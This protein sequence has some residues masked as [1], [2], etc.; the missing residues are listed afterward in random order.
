MSFAKEI[1]LLEDEEVGQTYV[2]SLKKYDSTWNVTWV[3]TISEVKAI[4]TLDQLHVFI[5]DQR[6]SKNE[7]GTEAFKYVHQ[8]NPRI[9]GVMLSGV[10]LAKDLSEAEKIIHEKIEYVNKE[11]VLDLPKVVKT[12]I[13]KYYAKLPLTEESVIVLKGGCLLKLF[14]K[15]PK[16]TLLSSIVINDNYIFENEWKLDVKIR[17]GEKV[18]LRKSQRKLIKRSI[19]NEDGACIAFDFNLSMNPFVEKAIQSKFSTRKAI[20]FKEELEEGYSEER[21]YDLENENKLSEG[22]I[23]QVNYEYNQIFT[24]YRV[25]VCIDCS[26]CKEKHYADYYVYEPQNKIIERR[27]A[28]REKLP[29]IITILTSN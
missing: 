25:H 2:D 28:F 1:L 20:K 8:T 22:Y 4:K 17:S 21:I 18:K 12:A 24:Q 3:K 19:V 29:P 6:L 15:K 9:Q 16:V 13:D 23:I 7:L 14:A 10:A 11:E 27:V 26:L 5:F